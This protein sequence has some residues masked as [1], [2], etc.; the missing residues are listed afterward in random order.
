[1]GKAEERDLLNVVTWKEQVKGFI[2]PRFIFRVKTRA[3]CLNRKSCAKGSEEH[4]IKL[5]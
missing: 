3:L 1:M 2:D 5:S 4:V